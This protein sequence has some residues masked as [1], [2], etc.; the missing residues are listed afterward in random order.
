[1]TEEVIR[2][3]KEKK[4]ELDDTYVKY[5]N[6]EQ[7]TKIMINSFYGGLANQYMYF[8]NPNLAECITKQGKN[9]I[10]YAEKNINTYFKTRWLTDTETHLKMGVKIKE[11]AAINNDIVIYCDTDSAYSQLDEV[12]GST[13][14]GVGRNDPNYRIT[15]NYKDGKTL[16]TTYCGKRSREEVEER[17]KV[18][19]PEVSSYEIK[20]I[21]GEPK[22]FALKLD[23]VFLADFFNKIFDEYATRLNTDNYLN[24]ELESYSDA[25]IWLA[26][27]K[28][29]QNLRWT[30]SMPRM[31]IYDNFS[32][33][34]SKGVELIQASSPNFARKKL[35][36]LVR[37]I[38]EQDKLEIKNLVKELRKV[39]EEMKYANPDEISWN[40][41]ATGYMQWVVDDTKELVM[42]KRT[43]ITTKGLAFYNY[44]LSKNDAYKLKYNRLTEGQKCK[45]YYCKSKT[46]EMFSYEPGNFPIEFAPE[47]DVDLMFEKTILNPINRIVT[48]IGF[49]EV[50]SNLVVLN[51]SKLF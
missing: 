16:D 2:K 29:I 43:P 12:V 24:F 36:Y 48:A 30:D 17:F 18:H 40:K 50:E 6:W 21:P 42:K 37:W 46:C 26:K 10:L 49:K 11:G 19:S 35:T 44:L 45:Y 47:V 38:F 13:D 3:I 23:E 41:K 9:A 34:K 14:W 28:Y 5:H 7:G 22:D 25:G 15:I 4:Q 1:M 51:S 33:I 31:D 8:F 39:K 32:K 20:L 27:K